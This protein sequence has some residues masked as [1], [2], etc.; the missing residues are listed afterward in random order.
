[1]FDHRK[2]PTRLNLGCGFDLRE[3]YVNV[4]L[5][6]NH[7]P[8]LVADVANLHMLPDSYYSEIVAQD[9]LEHLPRAKTQTAL[10]EWN[11]VLRIGG[12]LHLQTLDVLGLAKLIK[13]SK[14]QK[15]LDTLLQCLY[16]TQRY[17]GDFHTAGFTKDFLCTLLLKCGFSKFKISLRDEWLLCIE[18]QK[19]FH[20][21]PDPLLMLD[22][23]KD[24]LIGLYKNILNREPDEG[25]LSHWMS[26]LEAGIAREAVWEAFQEA[27][28]HE[29]KQ[30]K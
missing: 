22:D 11:R 18:A 29:K 5:H 3:G 14:S 6:E 19:K 13:K 24:F 8:D 16:G 27:A 12:T 17:P 21:S 1:M 15:S 23:N 25:G 30:K 10:Q 7:Q 26:M 20:I 28:E 9:I 4:D 2:S